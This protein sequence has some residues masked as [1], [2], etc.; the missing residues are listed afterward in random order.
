MPQEPSTGT[1]ARTS[2]L[3]YGPHPDQ[4][5]DLTLP[6][7]GTGPA[8]LVVFL[9]GGIWLAQYDR[10]HVDV[11]VD[12]L[13]DLG[14][15]VANLEYRRVGAGGGWP[16]TF[17]DVAEAVDALPG[18]IEQ[19]HPG[20]IDHDA[21]VYAGHSAGAHLALWAAL[22]DQLPDAAPGRTTTSPHV[23]GVLALAPVS[24]L[25][26]AEFDGN[27][28]GAVAGLLGGTLAEH[29]DRYAAADPSVLGTPHTRVV[30]VHGTQDELVPV[31]MSRAYCAAS[32]AE[33]T[34]APGGH[35][36]LIDPRSTAWPVVVAA[37]RRL[38][39]SPRG[40]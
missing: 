10:R 27:G 18:L 13:V 11:V 22:R 21:I 25:A 4:V 9:H 14:Y 20:R 37:L 34:E 15:A 23:V 1:S 16:T 5:A 30:V 28:R 17:T 31:E 36:P 2:T 3:S 39:P 29:P 24:D 8:P 32:G 33:L 38:V 35:F 19:A 6:A 7:H 12:A 26:H 40:A